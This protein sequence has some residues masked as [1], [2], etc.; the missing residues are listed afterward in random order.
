MKSVLLGLALTLASLVAIQADAA[1]PPPSPAAPAPLAD[2]TQPAQGLQKYLF[3]V[4]V[5]TSMEP[6]EYTSRAALF[7]LIHSG[8]FGHMRAGDT[9]GIW[10]F[11]EGVFAGL[12]PMQRWDPEKAADLAGNVTRFLKNRNLSGKSRVDLV[13]PVVL[14]VVTNVGDLN[15]FL[16]SDGKSKIVG[17]PFDKQINK[18]YK[19]RAPEAKKFQRPFVTLLLAR[20]GEFVTAGVTLAGENIPLPPRTDP[21]PTNPPPSAVAEHHLAKPNPPASKPPRVQVMTTHPSKATSAPTNGISTLAANPST[22]P[23]APA[24][25]D[26]NPGP[27]FEELPLPPTAQDM[28]LSVSSQSPPVPVQVTAEEPPVK[29]VSAGIQKKESEPA[30]LSEGVK[31]SETEPAPVTSSAPR[32]LATLAERLGPALVPVAARE[33]PDP[34]AQGNTNTNSG[35]LPVLTAMTTPGGAAS[36]GRLFLWLGLGLLAVTLGFLGVY[37]KIRRPPPVSSFITQSMQR[38]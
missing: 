16:I 4:D 28:P 17:T 8:M 14:G 12:Y 13:L 15:V 26:G 7:E 34:M 36:Y 2:L 23:P 29:V 6:F 38:K 18:I 11:N 9:F 24:P 25:N 32:P 20:Q 30:P 3:V 10:P 37:L 22:P 1:S 21:V 35:P 19:S 27:V 31:K 33:F 5:S